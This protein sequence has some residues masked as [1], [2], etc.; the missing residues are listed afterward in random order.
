MK[1]HPEIG[2]KILSKVKS[3]DI[4]SKIVLHHHERWDGRG[5]PMDYVRRDTI[6]I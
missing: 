2:Y 1:K 5:Y 6:R 3:L 4:I